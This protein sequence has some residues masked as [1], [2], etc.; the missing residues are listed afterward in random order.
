MFATF[1]EPF[2]YDFA[3]KVFACFDMNG[4]LY[5]GISTTAKGLPSSILEDDELRW[6]K[7]VG[8]YYLTRNCGR[9]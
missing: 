6:N 1:H 2:V 7:K 3:S 8:G 5:D 9:H 4:F